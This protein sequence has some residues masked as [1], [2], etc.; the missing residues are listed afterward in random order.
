MAPGTIIAHGLLVHVG[1]TES[2]FIGCFGKDQGGVAQFA[3]HFC[4]LA[5]KWQGRG[6]VVEGI[7]LRIDI[8]AFGAVA[9]D[10]AYV[11]AV[12]VG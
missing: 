11:E 4:V 10:T 6:V 3:I 12:T 7:Y 1:M 2:T 5:R 9:L 8:P